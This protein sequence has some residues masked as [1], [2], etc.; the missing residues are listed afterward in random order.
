MN[1]E[2]ETQFN[3]QRRQTHVYDFNLQISETHRIQPIRT[4]IF[5]EAFRSFYR[6]KQANSN[7]S[8][9]DDGNNHYYISLCIRA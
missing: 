8:L 9:L 3:F 6:E 4:Y 2:V 7:S 5:Q 1:K